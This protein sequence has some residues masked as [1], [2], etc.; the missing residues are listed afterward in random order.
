MRSPTVAGGSGTCW[1]WRTANITYKIGRR[2]V[3]EST[4]R[5]YVERRGSPPLPP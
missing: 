2:V 4:G 3:V 1:W 5:R